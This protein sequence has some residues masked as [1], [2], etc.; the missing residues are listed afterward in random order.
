MNLTIEDKFT[1]VVTRLAKL[2]IPKLLIYS[3]VLNSVIMI[4]FSLLSKPADFRLEFSSIG[5]KIFVVV[6]FGPL[7]ETT[8]FQYMIIEYAKKYLHSFFAALLISAIVFGLC[9]YY[10]F[11]YIIA[12][13]IS[14]LIMGGLYI[15]LKMKDSY[16]FLLVF[17]LHS[18]YNLLTLILNMI[19]F[20]HR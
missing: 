9:H 13:S 14:G 11:N 20:S 6:I 7:F 10:S 15:I 17:M 2:S 18:A 12:T 3:F 8:I 1:K 16:A 4:S 19:F 5:E